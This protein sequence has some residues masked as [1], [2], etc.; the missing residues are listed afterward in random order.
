MLLSNTLKRLLFKP[1]QILKLFLDSP[2]ADSPFSLHQI[3]DKGR[4]VMNKEPG[5]WYGVNSIAQ[6]L[7]SIFETP[8]RKPS[9][10][11]AAVFEGL[12]VITFQEGGIYIDVITE[13]I[14]Q[15]LREQ[16]LKS[17]LE[18]E[19]KRM[20]QLLTQAASGVKKE[21]KDSYVMVDDFKIGEV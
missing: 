8:Q 14:K 10:S 11:V 12:S 1:E 9:P 3:C 18:E 20:N 15:G 5:D 21:R 16:R 17:E 2:S 4:L 13:R 19:K 7:V 6:V